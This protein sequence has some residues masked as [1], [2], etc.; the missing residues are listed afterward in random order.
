MPAEN[1]FVPTP[2]PVADLAAASAFGGERPGEDA[3]EGCG[4]L[5]LP[6]LGTGRLYDGVRRYCTKGENWYVSE[7]EYPLPEIV[8][9]ENDPRRI[10]EFRDQH[11]DANLTIHEADFLLDPPAGPFDWVLANPPYTRYQSIPVDKR[12]RYRQRFD[13]AEGRYPL[14]GLFLEQA[15]RLLRPGGWL[16]FIVPDSLL[17]KSNLRPCRR[18]LRT[19]YI[20]HIRPLPR[21]V[22]DRQVRTT[23]LELHKTPTPGELRHLTLWAHPFYPDTARPLLKELGVEAIDEAFEQYVDR[24]RHLHNRIGYLEEHR[25]AEDLFQD[26]VW[27][28]EE[29]GGQQVT[30]G[31]LE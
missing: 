20:D 10:Q 28:L 14:Y 12:D 5:F 8:T 25:E 17:T 29:D 16:T 24:S 13:V 22:F 15:L 31:A 6:G 30:L 4:R 2:P 1:G 3:I 11:P 27:L 23:L 21:Q 9:V 7:F 19:L 26:W 18:R